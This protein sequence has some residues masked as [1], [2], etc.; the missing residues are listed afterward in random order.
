M[1][2]DS[3]LPSFTENRAFANTL[4]PDR[5]I[6]PH[7]VSE[8]KPSFSASVRNRTAKLI[9]D[10]AFGSWDRGIGGKFERYVIHILDSKSSRKGA[11]H[12]P[13]SSFSPSWFSKGVT[14]SYS[15]RSGSSAEELR[16]V[17]AVEVSED[18]DTESA[19]G[20]GA[21]V[22]EGEVWRFEVDGGCGLLS[23]LVP[24][25]QMGPSAGSLRGAG[26][27]KSCTNFLPY[28]P[29][30]TLLMVRIYSGEDFWSEGKEVRW[31]RM[32]TWRNRGFEELTE[33]CSAEDPS[34]KP[35][36]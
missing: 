2:V 18:C 36:F 10:D 14:W 9:V 27:Q 11:G 13:S 1:M 16:L 28:L 15:F 32:G 8:V 34:P 25:S 22:F 5:I 4:C 30:S 24:R 26:S 17:G 19:G 23:Y 31:K 35:T 20:E 29:I 6:H 21:S 12:P 3:P 7:P 33:D